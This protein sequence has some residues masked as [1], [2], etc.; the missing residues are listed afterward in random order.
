MQ[1]FWE[2][3]GSIQKGVGFSHFDKTH[4]T[5]LLLFVIVTAAVCL[6]YRK[7]SKDSRRALR[8]TI[9][10]LILLD[11]CGKLVMLLATGLWTKNY[12]PLHLCTVNIFL[13]AV[14]MFRPSKLIDNFLYAICIP[15]SI[16]ALL[17]PTWTKLPAANFM[18][19][20]SCT[21]HML[22][23]IYPIM[24]TVGGDIVPRIKDLWKCVLLLLG[25][26]V[27][28]YVINMWLDTNYMFLL[29]HENI[30]PLKIAYDLTGCH[31]VAYPVLLAVL[32]LVMYLPWELAAWS[33]RKKEVFSQ[34][35]S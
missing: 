21:V 20:H 32:V 31:L 30:P 11:E 29:E 25:M 24:L 16:A 2:T 5:W 18:H 23:A 28:V 14:H 19:I 9:G 17:V 15:S 22:L 4:L 3:S 12:L 13:I 35:K 27:P 1:Y 7:A 6:I 26:A 34:S 10:T 33:K 8:F